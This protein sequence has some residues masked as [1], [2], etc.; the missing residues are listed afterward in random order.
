MRRRASSAAAT[1]RARD[2][3]SSSTRACSTAS[4]RSACSA[5]RRSVTSTITPSIQTRPPRPARQLAAVDHPAHRAVGADEPVLED[6]RAAV[7]RLGRAGHH[8]LDVVRVHDAQQG[9]APALDEVRRR[10]ARDALDLVADELDGV[11][12]VPR[13]AVQDAGDVGHQRAQQVVARAVAR[14]LHAQSAGRAAISGACSGRTI[15]SSA[16]SLRATV[17]RAHRSTTATIQVAARRGSARTAAHAAAAPTA[18][19]SQSSTSTSAVWPRSI[20][21]ASPTSVSAWISMPLSARS[22]VQ[23]VAA[24]GAAAITRPARRA[25]PAGEG[26][27]PFT[28]VGRVVIGATCRP[29]R[30]ARR[31]TGGA[32]R[33]YVYAGVAEDCAAAIRS[34]TACV[35]PARRQRDR[36]GLAVDDALEELLAVLVGGQ[37]ALRPPAHVVEHD[38][39]RRVLLAEQLGDLGLHALGERGRRAGGRDRDR[40]RTGAQD[41]RQDEVAQRRHVDDV[42]EHRALL[43]VVVDADVDVGVV[44]R[45]D[46]HERALEVGRRVRAP[47]PADRALARELLELGDGVGRNERH[48][49]VAGEQA[50]DLLEADLAATDDEALRPVSFRQAM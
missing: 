10:V 28:A 18:G 49:A 5:S 42:D 48:V 41:R 50:L 16:P 43:G 36:V 17:A 6:E 12:A 2:A 25:R 46:H 23:S 33:S 32:L 11:A 22:G 39:E 8:R 13:R 7:G 38:R 27:P 20:A 44:R 47:L 30:A 35:S 14:R 4:R 29:Y 26:S 31:R 40:E 45:G 34:R 37:R 21:S 9:A 1:I 15:T 3:R 19:S 24:S